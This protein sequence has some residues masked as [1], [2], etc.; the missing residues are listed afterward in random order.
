[1][2]VQFPSARIVDRHRQNFRFQP[3]AVTCLAGDARHERANPISRELAFRFRVKPFHLR[4]ESFERP[5]RLRRFPVTADID[6][7]RL[8]ARSVIERLFEF[9]RQL[10]E[11]DRFVHPEVFHQRPL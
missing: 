2:N 1:M 8:V 9:I 3:R 6:L 10:C 5:R 11:R 7:D 4:H